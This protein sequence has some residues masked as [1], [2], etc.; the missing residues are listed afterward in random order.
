MWYGRNILQLVVI[1]LIGNTLLAGCVT[2]TERI[3]PR[4]RIPENES[5]WDEVRREFGWLKNEAAP[6]TAQPAEPFYKRAARGVK[7]TVSGWFRDDSVKLSADEIA[8]N[9]RRFER[10]RAEALQQL[11]EQQ[12]LDQSEAG[13]R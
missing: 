2:Q 11:R 5:V 3:Y 8:A 1:L 6:I 4:E 13:D 9:R 10:R 7:E 12:E